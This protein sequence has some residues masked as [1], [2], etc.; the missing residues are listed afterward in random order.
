M[1]LWSELMSVHFHSAVLDVGSLS[2]R[3]EVSR[4]WC[5]MLEPTPMQATPVGTARLGLGHCRRSLVHGHRRSCCVRRCRRGR[6]GRRCGRRVCCR[7]GRLVRRR[8]RSR[9]ISGM[10]RRRGVFADHLERLGVPLTV[11]AVVPFTGPLSRDGD[12]RDGERHEHDEA[13]Q[14]REMP[15]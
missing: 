15:T 6:I 10:C 7:R 1:A 14:Q 4:I 3:I 2:K 5:S 8:H 12:A 11:V 13:Q 9:S